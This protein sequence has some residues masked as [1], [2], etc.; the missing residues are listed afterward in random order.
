M[1]T[2]GSKI[3]ILQLLINHGTGD[4]GRL[5]FFEDREIVLIDFK[6]IPGGG[7]FLKGD[8]PL[9][10]VL[11][12]GFQGGSLLHSHGFGGHQKW[13]GK[14]DGGFNM[15]YHMVLWVHVKLGKDGG[16]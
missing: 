1:H 5:A 7:V 15:G 2:A 14:L 10:S 16:R 8:L 9:Q 4:R 11:K 6:D 12:N 13:G 3:L